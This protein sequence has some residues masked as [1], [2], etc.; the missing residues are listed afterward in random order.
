MTAA[1]KRYNENFDKKVRLR[2]VIEEGD[3]VYVDRPPRA[4]RA[5]ER[6]GRDGQGL[7]TEDMSVKL[8]LKTEGPF[9]V[10]QAT[11]TTVTVEQD[12]L[13]VRVSIDRVTRMPR[14]PGDR[15]MPTEGHKC[16]FRTD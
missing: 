13:P 16:S 10:R 6:C 8:L 9:R 2:P 11:D 5:A 4:F 7:G 12:G 1:Q 3:Q 15:T 14:G